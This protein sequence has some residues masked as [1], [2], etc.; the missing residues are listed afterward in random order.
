MFTGTTCVGHTSYGNSIDVWPV[1]GGCRIKATGQLKANVDALASW[2]M[3]HH[4]SLK[5]SHMIF[6]NRIWN[7]ARDAV[8]VWADCSATG[9]CA[10]VSAGACGDVTQGHYD[11]LHLTVL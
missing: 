1:G 10:R 4:A 8:G 9:R 5:V 3:T 6:C 11:R 7:P 2:L